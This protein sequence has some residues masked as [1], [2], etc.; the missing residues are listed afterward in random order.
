MAHHVVFVPVEE[1]RA[2]DKLAGLTVVSVR[3]TAKSVMA[4]VAPD[5]GGEAFEVRYAKGTRAGVF[6]RQ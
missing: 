3:Q 6:G 2:G 1:L 5:S 4:K